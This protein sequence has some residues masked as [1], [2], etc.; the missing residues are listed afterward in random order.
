MGAMDTRFASSFYSDVGGICS[1]QLFDKYTLG[2]GKLVSLKAKASKTLFGPVK[3]TNP[4]VW[5][6]C[7]SH[8][9][10]RITAIVYALFR[11]E[12]S[13]HPSVWMSDKGQRSFTKLDSPEPKW[14]YESK[15]HSTGDTNQTRELVPMGQDYLDLLKHQKSNGI[16]M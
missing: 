1:S 16:L 10:I 2:F 8:S 15:G 4:S 13:T 7:K 5:M 12:K 14:G 9:R 11:P 6:S 3:P